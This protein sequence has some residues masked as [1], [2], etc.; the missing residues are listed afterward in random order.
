M[1]ISQDALDSNPQKTQLNKMSRSRQFQSSVVSTR[2]WAFIHLCQLLII[3]TLYRRWPEQQALTQV[4]N[5]EEKIAWQHFLPTF[6]QSTVQTNPWQGGK[7]WLQ[8]RLSSGID[9]LSPI[10]CTKSGLF[11]HG[12][13]RHLLQHGHIGCHWQSSSPIQIQLSKLFFNFK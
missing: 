13:R 8:E 3:P 5:Q 4:Q 2:T 12:R 10:N 7:A 1:C 9:S 11:E 6:Q